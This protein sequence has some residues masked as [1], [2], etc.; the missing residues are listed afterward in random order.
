MG[1]FVSVMFI[2]LEIG[3]AHWSLL[4]MKEYDVSLLRLYPWVSFLPFGLLTPRLV[5]PL[6]ALPPS[7]HCYIAP[8]LL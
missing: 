8:R 2:Q 1:V 5:I 7:C 3:L 4:G 6:A